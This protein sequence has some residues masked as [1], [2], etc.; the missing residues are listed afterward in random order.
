MRLY[1]LRSAHH[2]SPFGDAVRQRLFAIDVLAGLAGEDRGYCVPVVG[3]GD[4]DG[5]DVLAVKHA[6]K[7]AIAV[8]RASRRLLRP[9][10]VRLE[11]VAHRADRNVRELVELVQQPRAHSAHTDEAQHDLLAG[12]N[13]RGLRTAR[14]PGLSPA[15]RPGS[16]ERDVPRLALRPPAWMPPRTCAG[17]NRSWLRRL[18]FRG[19]AIVARQCAN[20]K[21]LSGSSAR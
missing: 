5:V 15:R 13:G 14:Q 9:A 17:S 6:P 21:P 18:G 11:N 4:H 10:Q 8:R 12:R 1:L 3:G 20:H 2:G 7:V 16:V 19:C